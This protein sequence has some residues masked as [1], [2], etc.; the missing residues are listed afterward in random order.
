MQGRRRWAGGIALA[1]LLGL[2]GCVVT[3]SAPRSMKALN[4][5]LTLSAP[6]GFCLDAEGSRADAAQAFAIFGTCA[7]ISGVAGG[8]AP[9]QAAVLTAAVRADASLGRPLDASSAMLE[10]FFRSVPGRAALAR[11]GRAASVR[12]LAVR[13][14]PGLFAMKLRDTSASKGTPVAQDYW[15]G[16][17]EVR[18]YLVSLSVLPLL[19]HPVG[20]ADQRA[21]L[22]EFARQIQ[23]EN[24]TV[25]GIAA[26]QTN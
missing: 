9:R 26:A 5:A 22:V 21:L 19:N 15:R 2:A 7:A 23:Q 4:G 12:V 14:A 17:I 3:G 25:G 16:V 6:T 8:P 1:A 13:A 10:K 20:D 11:D 24:R 18:G